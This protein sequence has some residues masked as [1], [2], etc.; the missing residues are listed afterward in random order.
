[1]N[2]ST[3][4]TLTV[5]NLSDDM[6]QKLSRWLESNLNFAFPSMVH[7]LSVKRGLTPTDEP[8]QIGNY[9]RNPNGLTVKFLVDKP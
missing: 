4:V 9:Y 1:M 8:Y 7:S 6:A 3:T 2:G 5:P